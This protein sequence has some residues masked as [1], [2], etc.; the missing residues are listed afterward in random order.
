VNDQ[1]SASKA[2]Q[3]DA[4]TLPAEDRRR[5]PR[6]ALSLAV[7]V[8]GD[9]NFYTGLSGDISEGGVFVATH[10][11]LP[12]GTTVVVT[13]ALPTSAE[14]ISLFGTV[15]WVRGP[16]AN[17]SPE[18]NFGC[19]HADVKPGMGIQFHDIEDA[20]IKAIRGFM[21]CRSPEFFD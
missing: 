16:E 18:A 2:A 6:Y 8:K 17:A 5:H 11:A 10:T 13:I 21:R 1:I 12:I 20:P 15:Q 14:P 3:Q 19:L 9:N 4:N 7:T